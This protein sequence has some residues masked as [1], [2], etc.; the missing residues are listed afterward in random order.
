MTIRRYLLLPFFAFFIQF[1]AAQSTTAFRGQSEVH[2]ASNQLSSVHEFPIANDGPFLSFC[3][4]A[5]IPTA[6]LMIRFSED[7][8][9]WT[10]WLAIVDD[11]HAEDSEIGWTSALGYIDPQ[12]R[13]YQLKSIAPIDGSI[14]FFNPQF[15]DRLPAGEGTEFT[16]STRSCTCPLPSYRNRSQW[17]PSGNC[18]AQ[19]NPSYTQVTH[20]I[21]HHSAGSNTSSDWAA[22]VRSI[23]NFHVNDRGWSDI[24]YNW[25]IAPTGTIYQ[26]RGDNVMG[27]HFCS[28]NSKTMGTCMMG[29]YMTIQP[30]DT[31]VTSLKKLLSW[32][33]CKEN[34][35]PTNIKYHPSSGL[36]LYQVS[37]HRDG[38]STACPGDAFYPTLPAIR[39]NVKLRT[40][41]S[42]ANIFAPAP[43]SAELQD[44]QA[45]LSWIDNSDN[46][47]GFLLERMQAGEAEF[48]LLAS[49]PADTHSYLDESIE[50]GVYYG[51]R[52]RSYNA[53]DT[54]MYSNEIWLSTGGVS[55]ENQFINASTVS[56]FPNPTSGEIT[57]KLSTKLTGKFDIEIRT[58]DMQV[59]DRLSFEKSTFSETKTLQLKNKPAGLYFVKITQDGASGVFRVV[60]M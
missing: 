10:E 18:P 40:A 55:T 48:T 32:K 13:L 30:T 39:Q 58:A 20:L 38:C 17:C 6:G 44:N 19:S 52:L 15:T 59:I 21:V 1:L 14:R 23:W 22:V 12:Y 28:H 8:S 50:E 47:E 3:V 46:E 42:C 27:A 34:I 16:I 54:S 4:K 53:Q 26:G 7:G 5:P 37:G 49:L 9:D 43:L 29:T 25:L 24:G 31:A 2:L 35:D 33:C 45:L 60:K 56:L 51:Y 36:N 57:L 11:P 41:N